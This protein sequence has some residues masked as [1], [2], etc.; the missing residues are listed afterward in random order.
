MC[1]GFYWGVCRG[2]AVGVGVPGAPALPLPACCSEAGLSRLPPL[3]P[4]PWASWPLRRPSHLTAPRPREL[5]TWEGTRGEWGLLDV[6]PGVTCWLWARLGL[7]R[8]LVCVS[9]VTCSPLSHLCLAYTRALPPHQGLNGALIQNLPGAP[10]CLPASG[11]WV[12]GWGHSHPRP[13][14]PS[15]GG[16][17]PKPLPLALPAPSLTSPTSNQPAYGTLTPLSL[18]PPSAV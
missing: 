3:S 16:G 12:P 6:F 18:S 13:E 2:W 4:G 10:R 11:T 9:P 17:L 15:Q 7:G 1:S 8:W 14:A 5:S